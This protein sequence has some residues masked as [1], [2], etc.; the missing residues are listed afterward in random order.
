M[1]SSS[2]RSTAIDA[3]VLQVPVGQEWQVVDQLRALSG[4]EYAE[5]DY[6]ISIH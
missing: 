6:M 5:P 1:S 2:T 4:V 3:Q